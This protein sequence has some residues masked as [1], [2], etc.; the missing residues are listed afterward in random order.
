MDAHFAFLILSLASLIVLLILGAYF[1]AAEMAFCALNRVR[2][3][4]MAELGGRKGRRA[5]LVLHLYENRFDDVIS[6]LL[7]CNNLVAIAAAT[8]SVALLV[9]LIGDWGYLVSAIS[10]SVI[11][12]L[13]TDILPKSMAKEQPEQVILSCMPFV[14]ILM[15]VL[16]PLN[17]SAIRLKRRISRTFVTGTDV[18]IEDEQ[19]L[20]GQEIIFMANE[21]KRDGA[22]KEDGSVLITNAVWFSDLTAWDIITPRVDIVSI[23]LGASIDEAAKLF[24][25]SGYSRMPVHEG[26]LDSICGIVHLRDLL[27]C[28]IRNDEEP[29]LTLEDIITPAVFTITSAPIPEVL[30]LLKSEKS[31]MAIVSDEYGGTEGMVTMDDILE[32]LVGDIWDETDEVIEEFMDLGAGKHKISCNAYIDD[33]FEHFGIKAESASNTVGGWIMDM[34]GRIPEVNDSFL[35]ENLKVTV[36]KVNQLRVKECLVEVID[37][38]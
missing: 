34:L 13:F 35:F 29:A 26:S 11:T 9:R 4:S 16:T 22:F 28:I 25:E 19:A 10:V 24:K 5:K 2:I 14:S 17:W 7:I 21:A 30:K 23:P 31:H 32:R 38:E 12:I 36:T 33:M 18:Q 6:T 27:K 8:V 15:T 1:S 20:R 37:A 3:M